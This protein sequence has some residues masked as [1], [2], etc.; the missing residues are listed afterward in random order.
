MAALNEAEMLARGEIPPP[1]PPGRGARLFG[2][3]LSALLLG[4]IVVGGAW[5]AGGTSAAVIAAGLSLI[6]VVVIAVIWTLR[7]RRVPGAE[8]N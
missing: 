5:L 2:N 8:T 6:G 7:K 3:V 4:V 1:V